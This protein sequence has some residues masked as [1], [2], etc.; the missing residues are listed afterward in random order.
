ML[1]LVLWMRLLFCFV[2]HSYQTHCPQMRT[3]ALQW[4]LHE[5]YA[6]ARAQRYCVSPTQ[7]NMGDRPKRM[8]CP[9]R[10]FVEEFCPL[11]EK[12]MEKVERKRKTDSDFYDVGVIELDTTRQQLKIHFAGFS[13]GYDEW[14]DYDNERNY[15]PF[16]RLEKMFFPAEGPLE[17]RG[18]IFHRPLYRCIKTK[19]WS[20]RKDDPEVRI[21]LNAEPLKWYEKTRNPRLQVV[22]IFPYG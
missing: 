6:T 22:L 15:F 4:S 9:P 16:V 13:Q 10:R 11:S 1:E 8:S 12:K 19:L 5:V 18:Y 20:G 2:F 21:E 14:R 17:D 7:M 3:F